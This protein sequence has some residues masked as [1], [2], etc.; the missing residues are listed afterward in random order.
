MSRVWRLLP[1]RKSLVALSSTRAGA[2][3]GYRGAQSCVAAANDQHVI[4]LCETA[5][6]HL[7]SPIRDCIAISF[8]SIATQPLK[9]EKTYVES[10][11]LI[12]LAFALEL[13]LMCCRVI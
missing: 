5:H 1:P 6:P 7:I 11:W 12:T 9:E 8:F 10:Q 2:P 4:V 13:R 3:R